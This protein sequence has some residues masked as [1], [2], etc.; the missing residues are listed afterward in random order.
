MQ[1]EMLRELYL[2]INAAVQFLA[3]RDGYQLVLTS[4]EKVPVNAGDPDSVLR[5]I[6]LKRMLYVDPAMDI[7]PDVVSYLNLGYATGT[8]PAKKT[9]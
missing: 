2:K 5:A 1:A 6:S 9:P 3:K 7:T 4:D 8:S